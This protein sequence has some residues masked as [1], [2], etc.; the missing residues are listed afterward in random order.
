MIVL[1]MAI[2]FYSSA[3][4]VSEKSRL[5]KAY[6]DD[7]KNQTQLNISTYNEFMHYDSLLT[8]NYEL[9]INNLDSV[10][11]QN[12]SSAPIFST[13][14]REYKTK[15]INNHKLW[16]NVRKS[17]AETVA[18]LSEGGTIY[19]TIY[20]SQKTQDTKARIALYKSLLTDNK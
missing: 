13:N 19:P 12:K 6:Y 8:I 15:L 14:I 17:N 11:N 3:I 16:L 10:Y 20:S 9:L 2:T 1:T 4:G 5:Y 7:S 18:F